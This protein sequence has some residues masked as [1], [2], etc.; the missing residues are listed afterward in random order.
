[1]IIITVAFVLN[2]YGLTDTNQCKKYI[3]I[4]IVIINVVN[5]DL[6]C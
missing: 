2:N 5:I 4:N 6:C 1:L 3:N